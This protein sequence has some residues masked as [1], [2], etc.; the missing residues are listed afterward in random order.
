MLNTLRVSVTFMYY[1]LDPIGFIEQLCVNK[2]KPEL[3]C[4]GKCH[5]KKVIQ[6]TNDEKEASKIFTIELLLFHQPLS[7]Y[8][9]NA[10][11]FTQQKGA[12][13]Y[14]NL[15]DFNYKISCFHPPQVEV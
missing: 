8:Q 9:L 6:S 5:L 15:Y 7:E 12:F 10:S 3:K 2:D 14:S 11:L 1:K 13:S 4:N